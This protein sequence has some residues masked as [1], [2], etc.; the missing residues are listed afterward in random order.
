[1]AGATLDSAVAVASQLS[2]RTVADAT[3]SSERRRGV[4]QSTAA[5]L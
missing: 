3:L 1:M 4:R 2:Q 5:R